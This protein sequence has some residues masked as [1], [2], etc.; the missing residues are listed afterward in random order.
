[1]N[2]LFRHLPIEM[3]FT[4]EPLNLVKIFR[5]LSHLMI[6]LVCVATSQENESIFYTRA[7]LDFA[8]LHD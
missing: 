7:Y 2:V 4:L 6:L 3:I 5:S 8:L 1:M